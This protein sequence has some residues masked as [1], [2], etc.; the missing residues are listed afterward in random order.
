MQ[1]DTEAV[2]EIDLELLEPT[3]AELQAVE[4]G[5]DELGEEDKAGGPIP[6]VEGAM[7]WLEIFFK[8]RELYCGGQVPPSQLFSERYL[9]MVCEHT[10]ES[11]ADAFYDYFNAVSIDDEENNPHTQ[12]LIGLLGECRRKNI[13]KTFAAGIILVCLELCY[14]VVPV[15]KHAED[16]QFEDNFSL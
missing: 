2:D 13:P 12:L 16:Q 14:G 9:K 7:F 11:S 15:D 1:S 3:D 8:D 5:V 4:A 10:I 6:N